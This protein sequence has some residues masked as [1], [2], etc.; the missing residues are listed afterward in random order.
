[1]KVHGL[2]DDWTEPD[3]PFLTL[4]EVDEL[5]REMPDAGAALQVETYSP[6]PF[7]AASIV[8]TARSRVFVKRHHRLIRDREALLEEHRLLQWLAARGISVPEVLAN[9]SGDTA[10][11]RGDWTYEVHSLARGTDLYERELS[12]TPFLSARHARAAGS[13]LAS[14]HRALEEYPAPRRR[15]QTLVASFSIFSE[16]DPWQRLREYI[17]ARPALDAYLARKNWK[18]TTAEIV[19]PFHDELQPFLPAL[20]PMWTHNDFHASNLFWS[21]GVSDGEVTSIIDFGL[22]DR[23]TAIY[24]IAT[25]IERNGVRWL[26]LDGNYDT[27]VHEEQILALLEGYE[28]ARPLSEAERRG[29]SRLLPIVHTEFALSEADYFLRVLHSE[30][31]ASLAWDGY[32]L[33]H[34]AWFRTENGR[35]LLDRLAL[36]AERPRRNDVAP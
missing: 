10:I 21:N 4:V 25:A 3:W 27:V 26:A 19:M 35:R 12:W 28:S 18:N 23:T 1:M 29:L 8:R 32:F 22:S 15:A 36:W 11:C 34:A 6:R 16:S 33:G 9:H 24:D 17:A 31:K 7:S 5:L 14:L 20:R 2:K 30:E 13:A